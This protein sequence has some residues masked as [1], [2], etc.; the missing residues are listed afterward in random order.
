M[1]EANQNSGNS[2]TAMVALV[3]NIK[4]TTIYLMRFYDQTLSFKM[5]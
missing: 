5:R 4:T 3:Q 1:V 2:M